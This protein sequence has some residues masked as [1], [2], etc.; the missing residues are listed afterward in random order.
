MKRLSQ[1]VAASVAVLC[2]LSGVSVFAQT[3][4]PSASPSPAA[5]MNKMDGKMGKK[6]PV[7]DPKTGK[8]VKGGAAKMSGK[9]D[10]KMSG[11]KMPAR[12]PKTGRFLKASPA[13][14]ASPK[15]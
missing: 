8:F 10:G 13:P 14:V 6:M 5:K 4:K 3:A 12:D 9:M 7:R 15:M 2:A 1:V 11:K